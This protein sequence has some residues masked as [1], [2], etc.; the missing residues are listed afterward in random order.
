MSFFI[1]C[2]SLSEISCCAYP[3]GTFTSVIGWFKGFRFHIWINDRQ[4][5]SRLLMSSIEK[6]I[7]LWSGQNEKSDA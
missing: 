7:F 1:V 6:N 4:G 5:Y 3:T 2:K